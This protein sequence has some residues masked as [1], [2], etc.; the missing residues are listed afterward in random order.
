MLMEDALHNRDEIEIDASTVSEPWTPTPSATIRSSLK[1]PKSGESFSP[2]FQLIQERKVIAEFSLF[3]RQRQPK[4]SSVPP[5]LRFGAQMMAATANLTAIQ[6]NSSRC[7]CSALQ[8]MLILGGE[9]H[10]RVFIRSNGPFGSSFDHIWSFSHLVVG[11]VRS[12]V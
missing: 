9:R 8:A 3:P 6:R 12:H 2:Y 10:P 4:I 11:L 7:K 5:A 1:T